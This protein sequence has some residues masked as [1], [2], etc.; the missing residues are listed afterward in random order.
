MVVT[1]NPQRCGR[2]S[3]WFRWRWIINDVIIDGGDPEVVEDLADDLEEEDGQNLGKKKRVTRE[4]QELLIVVLSEM[5]ATLTNKPPPFCCNIS[6][7][8]NNN[9]ES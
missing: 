2:F 7:N 8:S 1:Q 9:N 3:W 4:A 6:N 5:S